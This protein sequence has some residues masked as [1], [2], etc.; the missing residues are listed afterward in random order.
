MKLPLLTKAIKEQFI[1]LQIPDGRSNESNR[2]PPFIT[3]STT[4]DAHVKTLVNFPK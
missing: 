3:T 1:C 4:T 2:F